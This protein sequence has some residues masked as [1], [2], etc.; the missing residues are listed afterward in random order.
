MKECCSIYLNE[1]FGGDADVVKE[2]YDEYA[3]S[4]RSKLTEASA[5][6]AAGDWQI[7]DRIAHTIKGNALAAGDTQMAET[8][9]SLRQAAN[10]QDAER[11]AELIGSLKSLAEE[12]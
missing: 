1:Q 9:I 6:H 7:L 11:S 8:A 2:I 5:A 4:T 3:A 10:L 12:L